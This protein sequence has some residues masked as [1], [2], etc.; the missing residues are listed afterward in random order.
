MDAPAAEPEEESLRPWLACAV[1]VACLGH[2]ACGARDP[3]GELR[4]LIERAEA[5][6][7]ARDTGFFRSLISADYADRRGQDRDDVVNMLRAYFLLNQRI[8]V[9]NRIEAIELFGD[10]AASVK[11]Q[12]A[13]VGL[14]E[15]RSILGIDGDFYRIELEL[16]REG[17]GWRVIGADWNRMLP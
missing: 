15:G 4:A 7:E 16:G 14:A 12:T 10:D 17:D 11:L 13:A 9:V 8:E 6:V 1:I 5:A 3:D 2:S